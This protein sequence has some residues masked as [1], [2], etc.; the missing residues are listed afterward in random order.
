MNRYR[1]EFEVEA[2]PERISSIVEEVEALLLELGLTIN[3]E[4]E[5]IK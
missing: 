5:E 1:L 2:E 4:T 3:V